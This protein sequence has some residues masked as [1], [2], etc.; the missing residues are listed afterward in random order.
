MDEAPDQ[1]EDL[2]DF[3]HVPRVEPGVPLAAP[4]LACAR[5]ENFPV[6]NR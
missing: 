2:E 1:R 5:L 4:A 6:T 3:A